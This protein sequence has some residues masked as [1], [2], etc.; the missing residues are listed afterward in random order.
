MWA[1]RMK[2]K[3]E[4]SLR[5]PKVLVPYG[6]VTSGT[7]QKWEMYAITYE[8]TTHRCMWWWCLVSPREKRTPSSHQLSDVSCYVGKTCKSRKCKEIKSK[9]KTEAS[10]V[11]QCDVNTSGS[12]EADLPQSLL[13]WCYKSA[14]HH[15]QSLLKTWSKTPAK[16]C[17]DSDL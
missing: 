17:I 12:L 10:S 14:Y 11:V 13:R 4:A 9:Q 8:C 2:D 3:L 5:I 7:Q 16:L 6:F 1:G 15:S